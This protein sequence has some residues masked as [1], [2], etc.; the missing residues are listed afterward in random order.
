MEDWVARHEGR[1]L[2]A[3]IHSD[4]E[5]LCVHARKL[6]LDSATIGL[7]KIADFDSFDKVQMSELGRRY[8][9]GYVYIFFSF[10]F[11]SIWTPL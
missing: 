11:S 7:R 3:F 2:W 10:I 9:W 1:G 8:L 5:V 6:C 4:K